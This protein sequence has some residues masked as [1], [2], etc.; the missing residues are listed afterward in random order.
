MELWRDCIKYLSKRGISFILHFFWLFPIKKNKIVLMNDH[1]YAYSDNLKYLSCYLLEKEPEKYDLYF[2][3]KNTEGI[4]RRIKAVKFGS[5][6]HFYHALTGSVVVTNNSGIVYLPIRK[7]QLVINTWH[8]GGPYKVTGTEALDNYWH[9]L[10]M[11]YNARKVNYILSSCKVFTEAEAPGMYYKPEQCVNCGMPRM[12]YFFDKTAL[13][14]TKRKVFNT[15]KL[16][17][18][19]KL[20]LYAPTFRGIFENYGGVITDEI[21]EID[22]KRLISVLQRKFGGDWIFA[23]RLHPRL[24]EVKFNNS[25]VINMSFYPDAEELLMAADVLV[26]DYSSVM[27]DFSFSRKPVFLFAKDIDD[28]EVKRGFYV[29]P[30]KWPY[31]VAV[32]NDEM[33]QNIIDYDQDAYWKR[34]ERHHE[35][36][37][38][39]EKG[40]ACETVKQLIDQHLD[41]V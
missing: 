13:E 9:N 29:P 37:G 18:L 17:T 14:K 40:I 20:V 38:S 7:K 3:L 16:S 32:T 35:E 1:S 12:D 30:E 27:W 28:Y 4:D 6:A 21:L 5:F 23:V 41:A 22:D 39:F 34:L 19:S 8:G 11:K 10:D 24:K 26:T 31:P 15:Y 33:E 2:L 25:N 36:S